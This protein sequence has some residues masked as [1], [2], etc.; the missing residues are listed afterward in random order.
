MPTYTVTDMH[1]VAA[2]RRRNMT[3]YSIMMGVRLACIFV[4]F[5][6]PV[7]WVWVPALL[8][9]FLPMVATISTIQSKNPGGVSKVGGVQR[10][11]EEK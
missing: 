2:Q 6:V 8:A 7:A 9:V 10:E 4:C 11:L 5:I 3:N 1:D